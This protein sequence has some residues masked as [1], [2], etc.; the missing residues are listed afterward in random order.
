MKINKLFRAVEVKN[1]MLEK[2]ILDIVFED[3]EDAGGLG[4]IFSKKAKSPLDE[5]PVVIIS[6][7]AP[8]YLPQAIKMFKKGVKEFYMSDIV[9]G[10]K[11]PS[12]AFSAA[13]PNV[14]HKTLR[15]FI[16]EISEDHVKTK[17]EKL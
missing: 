8:K 4:N 6:G 13:V 7:V 11:V 15:E 9:E 16:T 1:S 14:A 3:K 2:T 12:I 17:Q 5:T 10:Y